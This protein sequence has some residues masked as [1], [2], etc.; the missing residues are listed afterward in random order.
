MKESAGVGG[1]IVIT[2]AK[3][4]LIPE[5]LALVN[6]FR[7]DSEEF[8][9]MNAILI[10][11]AIKFSYE[12]CREKQLWAK[13]VCKL[14]SEKAVEVV[15]FQKWPASVHLATW[16]PDTKGGKM[17]NKIG[18]KKWADVVVIEG[19]GRAPKKENKSMLRAANKVPRYFGY[20][21]E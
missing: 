11:P 7:T 4:Y 1:I 16:A 13:F 10:A 17:N 19:G 8:K 12:I 5:A 6:D 14:V 2:Y 9:T 15:Q 18:N 20:K 3:Y 21:K